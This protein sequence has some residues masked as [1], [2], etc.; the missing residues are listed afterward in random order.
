MKKAVEKV[1]KKKF[2]LQKRRRIEKNFQ[3]K[4]IRG[5][6]SQKGRRLPFKIYHNNGIKLNLA[7]KRSNK[8]VVVALENKWISVHE[9]EAG[10]RSIKKFIKKYYKL[11]VRVYPFVA[12]TKRPSDMRM[13]KGKGMRI[14]D[15]VY[16][17][18]AGKVIYELIQRKK[19]LKKKKKK[20]KKYSSKIKLKRKRRRK[21]IIKKRKRP[22][23]F[24][25]FDRE[26][27]MRKVLSSTL[28]KLS[29]KAK[30]RKLQD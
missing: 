20:K 19:Q 25:K 30:V 1:V 7:L 6:K 4:I 29:I 28:V 8:F 23:I 16:P 9:I 21:I 15:W 13:G 5:S 12:I 10:R 27:F 18:K 26:A 14:I 3:S 24:K 17:I 2:F 11:R 22:S